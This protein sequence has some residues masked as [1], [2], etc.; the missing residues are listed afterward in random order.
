MELTRAIHE[1]EPATVTLIYFAF[2][3]NIKTSDDLYDWE[4][5]SG[6]TAIQISMEEN[7]V[8]YLPKER[9]VKP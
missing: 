7:I 4:N 3:D 5:F 9:T 1:Q 6:N 8:T 2:R